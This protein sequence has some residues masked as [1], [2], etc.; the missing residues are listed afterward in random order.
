MRNVITER[1]ATYCILSVLSLIIIFHVFVV[2]GVIP[3]QIVWGGRLT[4]HSQMVRFEAVSIAINLIMLSIVVIHA[5]MIQIRIKPQII[6]VAL[7]CMCSLFLLNTVGNIFS[8]NTLETIV[9]TPLTAILSLCS[10]RLAIRKG[11]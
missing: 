7:W 9:F 3:F 8:T 6:R 1:T 4:D 11:K 10:F 5:G 2:I